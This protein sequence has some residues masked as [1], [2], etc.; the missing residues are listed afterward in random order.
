M[1]LERMLED[2]GMIRQIEQKVVDRLRQVTAAIQ[3]DGHNRVDVIRA[4]AESE[5]AQE[6]ALAATMRPS[7]VGG[8]LARAAHVQSSAAR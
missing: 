8:A 4:A 3:Q 2:P 1:K 6:L 5:A 7:I